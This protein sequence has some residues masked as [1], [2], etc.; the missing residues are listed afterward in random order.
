MAIAAAAVSI[1]S[2][3][4]GFVGQRKAQR[5]QRRAA[6]NAQAEERKQRAIANRQQA[7]ERR[8]SI[9]QSIAQTRVLQ[10]QAQAF[11][12]AASGGG[13]TSF[14]SGVT[15]SQASDF[16]TALGSSQTQFAAAGAIAESQNR[17]SA[18]MQD[19]EN[20]RTNWLTGAAQLSAPFGNAD[21]LRGLEGAWGRFQQG[22][23]GAVISG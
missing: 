3:V 13:T 17:Q 8:R 15:S 10:A 9:R 16:G 7:L 11:G 19:F 18:A 5:E 4:T 22:G 23:F 2:A 6:R 21:T 14:A 1:F 20:S 12:F